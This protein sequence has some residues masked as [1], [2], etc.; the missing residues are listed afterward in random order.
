MTTL[1]GQEKGWNLWKELG[2]HSM[3]QDNCPHIG[4]C[5]RRNRACWQRPWRSGW[6]VLASWA[7]ASVLT[8]VGWA[9][10]AYYGTLGLLEMKGRLSEEVHTGNPRISE[11]EEGESP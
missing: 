2:W 3:A 4:E 7:V 9:V 8:Q 10:C 6:Y 1:L 5:R 11:A